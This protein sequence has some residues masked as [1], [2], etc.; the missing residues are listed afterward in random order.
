MSGAGGFA[1]ACALVFDHELVGG[2]GGA[3]AEYEAG[4][5]HDYADDGADDQ[6]DEEVGPALATAC[7]APREIA[8]GVVVGDGMAGDGTAGDGTSG[9]DEECGPGISFCPPAATCAALAIFSSRCIS[10][11]LLLRSRFAFSSEIRDDGGWD[12]G[13]Y[14]GECK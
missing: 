12:V 8:I 9:V 14:W 6:A 1:E 4:G 5:V 7:L 3:A 10:R 2:G 11:S 13:L